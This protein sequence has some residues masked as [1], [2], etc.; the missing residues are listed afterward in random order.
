MGLTVKISGKKRLT[1]YLGQE[2]GQVNELT[3]LT[4]NQELPEKTMVRQDIT[5][6]A[7]L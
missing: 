6:G 3:W 4:G 2:T 5:A 7:A 1:I